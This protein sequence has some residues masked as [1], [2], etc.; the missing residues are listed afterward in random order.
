MLR[1]ARIL[2]QFARDFSR[3][4]RDIVD[5]LWMAPANVW[6]G[7]TLAWEQDMTAPPGEEDYS[8]SPP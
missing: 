7:E 4:L 5:G 8:A 3:V 2:A 1:S 6:G